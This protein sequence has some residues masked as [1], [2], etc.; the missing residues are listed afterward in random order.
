MPVTLRPKSIRYKAVCA[1]Y[2]QSQRRQYAS[3]LRQ[4]ESAFWSKRID[5]QQSQ[6]RQLW[7]S[8]D[9]LLGQ[10]KTPLSSDIDAS[11]LISSSTTRFPVFGKLVRALMNLGSLQPRSAVSFIPSL[12]SHRDWRHRDGAGSARQTVLVR[13]SVATQKQR[14][15]ASQ[16]WNRVT[17]HRVIG[18]PG[19]QFWPGRVGSRVNVFCV[20]TRCCDP[21]PWTSSRSFY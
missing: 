9:E 7:R 3:L 4:K 12:Q 14:Q 19:Q 15:R 18:S 20:Q 17:G 16:R 1:Y 2:I 10:D 5:A 6:P 11:A 8:F 13:P 21:V